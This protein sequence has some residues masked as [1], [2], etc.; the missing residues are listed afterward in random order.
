MMD[1]LF[2]SQAGINSVLTIAFI[3]VMGVGLAWWFKRKMDK[4]ED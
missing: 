2:K 1:L 4:P 3:C